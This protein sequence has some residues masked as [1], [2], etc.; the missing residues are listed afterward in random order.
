MLALA[1]CATLQLFIDLD[2]ELGDHHADPSDRKPHAVSIYVSVSAIPA[3]PV[4]ILQHTFFI[5]VMIL[6]ASTSSSRSLPLFGLLAWTTLTEAVLFGIRP[7]QSR[8]SSL[9]RNAPCDVSSFNFSNRAIPNASSPALSAADIELKRYFHTLQMARQVVSMDLMG[10][11]FFQ[12][13]WEPSYSCSVHMRMGCPGDGGKWICD[14]HIHLQQSNRC[15]VYSF[16]SNNDFSFETAVHI[17]NPTCE[18]HTF[19]PTVLH[20]S[21]LPP[22]VRYHTWGLGSSAAPYNFTLSD[23]MRELGHTYVN[24]LKIDCEGCELD[25]SPTIEMHP[26]TVGQIQ[27]EVHW[28]SRPSWSADVH[29]LFKFL[30]R[31]GFVIFSKE[32]NI[33]YSDGSA[34]EFALVHRP[35]MQ[36]QPT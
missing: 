15:V 26:A 13:N 34:V 33:Q 12:R 6:L 21:L 14:P 3:S 32:P 11:A 7:H 10:Q 4:G 36:L 19:D 29:A 1:L 22:F 30:H 17:F 23:V 20:P 24:V 16:G 28:D 5:L 9:A 8:P 25:F 31:E 27:V 35:E 18:L 2:G